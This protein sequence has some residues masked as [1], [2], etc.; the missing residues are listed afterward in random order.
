MA[1]LKIA[2]LQNDTKSD[3]YG[4]QFMRSFFS[5]IR[6]VSS[7]TQI[8]IFDPIELQEYPN[9]SDK[10]DA[11]ILS[12]GT[13]PHDLSIPWVGRIYKFIRDTVNNNPEQTLIGICWGHQ[14]VHK[15]LGGD[16]E[17]MPTGPKLRVGHVLTP[18]G[19]EFFAEAASKG[20]L[21]VNA[22]HF[23]RVVEPAPGFKPLLVE[24]QAFLSN[25]GNIFTMQA[26]P[27]IDA[28]FAEEL[29]MK[30]FEGTVSV[31]VLDQ[32]LEGI[33]SPMDNTLV[34]LRLIQWIEARAKS[35]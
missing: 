16:V 14:A 31:D 20:T 5:T 9:L 7:N 8:S 21:A 12:G 27:E 30:Y 19:V 24:N 6:R 34:W 33:K 18:E 28:E 13:T 35:E 29:V 15:A 4:D 11:I 2:I 1:P 3:G 23:N 22:M 26:H 10:Y 25:D 32:W 17:I